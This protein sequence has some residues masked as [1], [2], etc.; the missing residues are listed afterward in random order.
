[1]N[2]TSC[3]QKF[4][5][6]SGLVKEM[7]TR[8]LQPFPDVPSLC[9]SWRRCTFIG[10]QPAR[11]SFFNM[12]S[13]MLPW[14]LEGD[15]DTRV[16]QFIQYYFRCDRPLAQL[17]WRL[18][19]FPYTSRV[20]IIS[21]SLYFSM[22]FEQWKQKPKDAW[23]WLYFHFWYYHHLVFSDPCCALSL[24]P[25]WLKCCWKRNVNICKGPLS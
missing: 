9:L 24:S 21:N 20:S 4:P 2:A 15:F 8:S 11:R 1:M 10:L 18:L 14:T 16:A 13:V 7:I 17:F 23:I 25:C 22:G 6:L 3:S 12:S 19:F 5:G